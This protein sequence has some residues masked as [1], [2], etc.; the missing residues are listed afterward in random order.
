MPSPHAGNQEQVFPKR[1]FG[2]RGPSM[3]VGNVVE[4]Q[5][6]CFAAASNGFERLEIRQSEIDPTGD[7]TEQVHGIH[8]TEGYFRVFGAPVIL[9]RTFTPQED[10]PHG[11]KVVV[12]SYDL[13]QQKFNGDPNAIGKLLWLGKDPYQV[14]GVLGKQFAS[15][16]AAQIWIPFQLP[17]SDTDKNHFF[18]VAGL[19]KPGITLAEANA[20]MRV[21]AAQFH[22]IYHQENSRQS[23]AVEPLRNSI[24]GDASRS[25]LL[26]WA[27]VSL[28]L[29]I[30]CANVA[31]LLLVR[32]TGRKREFAIRAALGAGHWHTIRQLLTESILL[33]LIGGILGMVLGFAGVRALLTVSPAGLPRIGQ[34]GAGL[35]I[36]WRVLAFTLAV[37]L[38]TGILFGLF[39]AFTASHADLNST[40]KES[41]T[42]TGISFRQSKLL[43]LLIVSEVSL[44]L[45]LLIST[46]RFER[47]FATFQGRN[48]FP[49]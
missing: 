9:G 40:L 32:A 30:A 16:P 2:Y 20:Q 44:A 28:V 12:I 18:Q 42:R 34:S 25:L 3:S 38:A 27:A 8:V 7:R 41:G 14:I 29:L 15:D 4:I 17:L 22:R 48:A 43:S 33:S 23:F 39:P 26:L 11:G 24:I 35:G 31:N 47:N 45:V 13:W 6:I 19:L 1:A 21:A 10:S 46:T 49:S 36:D 5:G 37:S